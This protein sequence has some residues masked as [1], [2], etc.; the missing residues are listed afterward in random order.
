MSK[1]NEILKRYDHSINHKDRTWEVVDAMIVSVAERSRSEQ[2]AWWRD[3]MQHHLFATEFKSAYF[4]FGRASGHT[5]CVQ[6]IIEKYTNV[7]T[8]H[9]TIEMKRHFEH[10]N[11]KPVRS[12]TIDQIERFIMDER[13]HNRMFGEGFDFIVIDNYSHI[14]TEKQ[15]RNLDELYHRTVSSVN[16]CYVHLG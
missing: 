13:G 9:P 2:L 5:N 16:G 11:E 14:R 6:N 4:N 10:S 1:L 12:Y 8:F 7:I 15:K 3:D